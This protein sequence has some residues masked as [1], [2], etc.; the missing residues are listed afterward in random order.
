MKANSQNFESL[1]AQIFFNVDIKRHDTALLSS[2]KSIPALTYQERTGWTSYPPNVNI[3]SILPFHT[4]LFSV[5]P[6]FSSMI[7]DGSLF[8]FTNKEETT[9]RGMALTISFNSQSK[10]DSVY[11]TVRKLYRQYASKE[12]KR[13]GIAKPVEE[14]KYISK[15]GENFIIISKGGADSKFFLNIAFNCRDYFGDW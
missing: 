13:R 6:Y 12:I 1:T 8:I 14:T 15:D 11:K 2:L 7:E 3:D 9:I 5:H 10:F 4:F